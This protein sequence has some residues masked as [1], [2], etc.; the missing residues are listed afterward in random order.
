MASVN[1]SLTVSVCIPAFKRAHLVGDA[2]ESALQQSISPRE[3]LVFDNCSEDGIDEV[4]RGIGSPLVKLSVHPRN[5]GMCANWNACLKAAEGDIVTLLHSDDSYADNTALERAV[6]GF[7]R[8][9]NAAIVY[10]CAVASTNTLGAAPT[11]YTTFTQGR[12][13]AEHVY[14]MGQLPCSSTFYSNQS[15]KQTTGF[16]ER[17]SVCCDEEFNS[18]M[19][20]L[21]DVVFCSTSFAVYRRHTGHTMYDSWLRPE[22]L[23]QYVDSTVAMAMNAGLTAE[24]AEAEART[25]ITEILWA[26]SWIAFRHGRAD[27]SQALHRGIWTLRPAEYLNP[28]KAAYCA[29]HHMP[30]G[31]LCWQGYVGVKRSVKAAMRICTY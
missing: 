28:R 26:S 27:A 18:R 5:I 7:Q 2:I 13:A 30:G 12:Q 23:S 29:L 25:R 31:R 24:A 15:V 17:F 6:E 20:L 22:F 19:S 4:V 11:A 14:N 9:P 1:K 16:S 21:G 3:I 8:N 10:S